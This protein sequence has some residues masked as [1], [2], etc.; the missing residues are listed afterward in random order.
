[1]RHPLG[2]RALLVADAAVEE[3]DGGGHALKPCGACVG[4]H[5]DV[6]QAVVLGFSVAERV[7]QDAD[8]RHVRV[9]AALRLQAVQAAEDREQFRVAPDGLR[10]DA[11]GVRAGWSSARG[12]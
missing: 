11:E 3:G 1:R 12:W 8:E 7:A 10:L 4:E 5:P 2:A 6:A 9:L